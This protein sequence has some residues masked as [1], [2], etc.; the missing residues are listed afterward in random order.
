MVAITVVAGHALLELDMGQVGDQLRENSSADIHPPLFR[1]CWNAFLVRFSIQI[2]FSKKAAYT[3]DFKGFTDIRKVLYRTAVAK[4]IYSYVGDAR[5]T[6]LTDCPRDFAESY[7][8]Y[9]SAWSEA[10]DSVD[11]HPHI[12]TEDEA[13][14]EGFFRGLHGDPTGGVIELADTLQAYLARIQ[15][16]FDNVS[17]CQHEVEALAVRYGAE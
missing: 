6:S 17:K 16:A 8:R 11:S 5:E 9:V 13:V 1:R 7:Y 14:L 4:L 12:P 15:S 3:I 10:A 2:V